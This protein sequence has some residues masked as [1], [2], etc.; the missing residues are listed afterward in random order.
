MSVAMTVVV[1]MVMC[2]SRAVTVGTVVCGF[3]LTNRNTSE[4][5]SDEGRYGADYRECR[6]KQRPCGGY[7]VDSGLRR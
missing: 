5:G 6:T 7:A 2:F 4:E 1:A 3:G